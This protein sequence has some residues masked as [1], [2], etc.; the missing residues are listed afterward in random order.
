MT[1][2][3]NCHDFP[4]SAPVYF[5]YHQ[6]IFYFFSNPM[7]RHILNA[8]DNQKTSSSIFN[9]SDKMDQIYGIQMNGVLTS[10]IK[11]PLYID[12]VR[13]YVLKFNFLEIAFGARVWT[14]KN[15]FM[16]KFKSRLYGF[17]PEKVYL[18]DNSRPRDKRLKIDLPITLGS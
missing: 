1:L 18:S 9:D 2:G 4:W 7:S 6:G 3:V 5:V 12:I 13:Q 15:F 17:M 11:M 14:D 8:S 10:K 16:E